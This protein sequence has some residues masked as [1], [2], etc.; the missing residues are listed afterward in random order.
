[1]TI[2][3]KA[4]QAVLDALLSGAPLPGG[5]QPLLF[6][7]FPH[8]AETAAVVLVDPDDPRLELPPR[9]SIAPAGAL[10][11]ALG[12]DHST[13][14]L[15]FLTPEPFPDRVGVRLRMSQMDDHARLVSLGEIIAT[16][17]TTAAGDLMVT[18]PTH[19]VAH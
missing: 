6:P 1:M 8:I 2:E 11:T 9:V 7:D 12:D 3:R 16:F 13:P 18:E 4:R 10:T 17:T 15:E 5:V 14:V 19:V